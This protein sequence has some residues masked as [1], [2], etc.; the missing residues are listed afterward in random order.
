MSE[1]SSAGIPTLHARVERW[2]TDFNGH[3]NVRFFARSFQL[4]AETVAVRGGDGDN[5]GGLTAMTRHMRFHRELFVSAPLAIRSTRVV[6]GPWAGAVL[7]VLTSGG[8][9]SATALDLPGRGAEALPQAIEPEIALAMPRSLTRPADSDWHTKAGDRLDEQGPVRPH[10][11]DHAR[12]LLVEEIKRRVGIASHRY[13]GDLGFAADYVKTTG[14][15]RML[16]EVRMSG[17]TTV[18]A[19]SILRVRSRLA[20]VRAR[21]FTA[22]HRLETLAG[23]GIALVEH[24]LVAV[25][26]QTRKAV[27]VPDFMRAAVAGKEGS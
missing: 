2:E 6:S 7:H 5:P 16:V 21:S 13:M 3:W 19:G 26:L 18:R 11:L 25:D 14:V 4:A 17:T 1:Q 15:T 23:E 12:C 27:A 9:V 22:E 24:V 20:E 10:E 8:A